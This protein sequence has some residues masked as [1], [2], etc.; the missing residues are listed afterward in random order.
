MIDNKELFTRKSADYSRFRPA[1]PAAA[2]EWLKSKISGE[3]VLDVGAGTGIFTGELLRYFQN[4]SAV[5]P[6]RDMREAFA[7]FLP[8]IYCS[9]GSGEATGF[10]D[11]SFD[12]ITVAQAFHWLDAERFKA[13]AMRILRPAGKVA[14]IWN[15]SL[16]CDFTVERNL[17]CQKYCPRFRSGHAGKRSAEE[18][19]AFLRHEYFRSVE[20]VEFD[21]PFTMDLTAFE[22]N[23]RSRSYALTAEDDEF[24]HFMDELRAVF[25][26]FAENNTVTEPQVTQIYFG[27]F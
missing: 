20:V 12:L 14:I 13:E 16:Q 5:E 6:N 23:M 22:G 2:V 9:G 15:T 4:V 24:E 25:R 1:Y 11:G 8:G 26:R 27:S 10:P 21:N 7:A 3:T 17:I 18:G 19:D